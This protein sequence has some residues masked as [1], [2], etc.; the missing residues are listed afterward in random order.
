MK[1]KVVSWFIAY[2]IVLCVMYALVIVLGL[3]F[4]L[5]PHADL[6]MG[7]VEALI[8]GGMFLGIGLIFLVACLVPLFISPRPWVWI[9]NLVVIC[10]GMTSACTLPFCIPLLIFWLKP[11][12]KRYYGRAA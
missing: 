8:I 12:T 3:V 2:D 4:L 1:P 7:P 5:M 6:D 9:Y 10:I 11:E